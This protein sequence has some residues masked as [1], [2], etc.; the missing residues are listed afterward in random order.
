VANHIALMGGDTVTVQALPSYLVGRTEGFE[1]EEKTLRARCGLER[2]L[3]VLAVLDQ[4]AGHGRKAAGR[5][6]IKDALKS[7]ETP[8]SEAEV[9]GVLQ[10]L[11]ELGLVR[12][13]VGRHG[14]ELSVQGH[15]FFNWLTN[16]L[17]TTP[18]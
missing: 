16:R 3:S 18:V 11:G 4:Y 14:S 12:S 2:A 6:S 1:A 8:L 5:N 7:K 15:Q 9:R 17:S 13:S 10:V